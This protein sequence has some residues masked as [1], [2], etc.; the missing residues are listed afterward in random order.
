MPNFKAIIDKQVNNAFDKLLA[1]GGL[2]EAVDFKFFVSSGVYDVENDTYNTEWNTVEKVAVIASKAT[3]DDRKDHGA[4][5]S[6]TK[7]VLP[8]AKLPSKPETDTDKVIR[9]GEE[10]DV[11]KTAEVPGDSIYLVFIYRT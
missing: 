1:P 8:A 10:W 4:I 3:E 5:S 7:L 6:D 2:T 11:R 9:G